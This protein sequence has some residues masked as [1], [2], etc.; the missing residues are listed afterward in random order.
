V[1]VAPLD[2]RHQGLILEKQ[3]QYG[4][5]VIEL[6]GMPDPVPFLLEVEPRLGIDAV[7]RKIQ[8]YTHTPSARSTPG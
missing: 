6:E 7:V 3:E 5:A 1:L 2:S 4:Y 8:G